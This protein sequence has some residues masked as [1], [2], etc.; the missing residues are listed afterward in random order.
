MRVSVVGPVYPYRGGIAHYTT[1]LARAL[2]E[3]GP[4]QVVSFRRQYPRW[5]YP[6]ASDKDPSRSPLK[7]D[8]EYILDPLYPW[9]W[10]RAADRIAR[11][12]PAMAVL[13]WWTTFWAP[14]LAAV[15]RALRRSGV[16]PVFLVHNALPHEPRPWDRALARMALRQGCAFLVQTGKEEKRLRA[17]LAGIQPD[18]LVEVCAHPV[19]RRFAAQHVPREEARRRLGL[20]G[21]DPILLFF[22]FVRPYK[23]LAYLLDAAAE[24]AQAGLPVH[25]VVAGEFWK[26][27]AAYVAQI[28]RLRLQ[29]R[30][31]LHDRYIHDEEIGAFFSAADVFVAPYVDATQSGALTIARGFGLPAVATEHCAAGIQAA[32]GWQ[33][34]VVPARDAHGLAQAIRAALAQPGRPV[35]PAQDDEDDG[36]WRHLAD[37][38]CAMPA[39]WG[40]ERGG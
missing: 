12:Q 5:L 11:F 40:W 23:G 8:A 6:G 22:V 2:A 28:K 10:R 37:V 34:R 26:D 36:G 13:A 38:L 17:L 7:I 39:R 14:G 27:K 25:V 21:R 31:H 32:D 35:R 9:T 15:A 24:L 16:R 19:Y 33:L 18:P 29:D 30:V 1:L 3:Q 4:A 20:P